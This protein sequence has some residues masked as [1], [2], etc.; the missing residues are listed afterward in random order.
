MQL[1][2]HININNSK[3]TDSCLN[4]IFLFTKIEGRKDAEKR[5][6][7]VFFVERIH[8]PFRRRCFI[9]NDHYSVNEER[10]S[11][12]AGTHLRKHREWKER[13]K[14]KERKRRSERWRSR[15]SERMAERGTGWTTMWCFEGSISFRGSRVSISHWYIVWLS[16]SSA[17]TSECGSHAYDAERDVTRGPP[18]R[19][20]T[21]LSAQEARFPETWDTPSREAVPS[22]LRGR[23]R[24]FGNAFP[25]FHVLQL[26]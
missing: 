25:E 10:K 12:S 24:P 8:S 9:E 7:I 3:S 14:K 20:S 2:S 16:F 5:N 22:D 15:E 19:W 18:P 13:R 21:Q 23:E 6:E 11:I 4:A 1:N 26:L 17:L